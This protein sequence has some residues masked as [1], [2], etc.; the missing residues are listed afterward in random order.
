[1]AQK[2]VTDPL[3]WN[4]FLQRPEVRAAACRKLQYESCAEAAQRSKLD[5]IERKQRRYELMD[6]LMNCSTKVKHVVS[7]MFRYKITQQYLWKVL[8]EARKD[9]ILFG[10]M[11]RR[12]QVYQRL[13]A[14][15]AEITAGPY[16]V[17]GWQAEEE[18]EEDLMDKMVVEADCVPGGVNGEAP[19]RK[20]VLD[21]RDIHGV[22][23]FGQQIKQE[24]NEAFRNENWE[25]ALTRYCQGDELLKNFRAEPHLEKENQDLTTVHRA[26]LNNK[27][28]AA[29]K[30]DHWQNALKASE[31][32][33]RIKQDDEK[34]LFRKAQ[35]LEGLGRTSEALETLDEIEQIAE[36]MEERFKDTI[37]D[38]VEERRAIIKDMEHGA[39][40]KYAH[41]LKVMGKK[42][43]FGG[44]RFLADG[45][46][47]PPVLTAAEEQQLKRMKDKR[48]YLEAKAK[49]LADRR[50]EG[51]IV[52]AEQESSSDATP[53]A[54]PR[55]PTP[56][57]PNALGYRPRAERSV[58]LT[59]AQAQQLLVELLEAYSTQGFQNKVHADARAAAFETPA[60]L[61]RLRKTALVVQQPLLQKWGF[62]PSEEGL[63][64][65]MLCLSDHTLRSEQLRKLADETTKMLYGGE[66]G[67]WDMLGH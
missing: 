48:E 60:F 62:D 14:L 38:D 9:G 31:D 59:L 49:Y 65:M 13:L 64:E 57:E 6:E 29:L 30:M 4:R 32:A 52:T 26:C 18:V 11:L 50:R 15:Q 10:D 17:A 61:R 43:V 1:M 63:Q 12:P 41:M 7:P 53:A 44:G 8:C 23:E 24:G 56:N 5:R 3:F 47:P 40:T 39:A 33:L 20:Q 51:G 28:N 21:E 55:M 22:L 58:T 67:M 66:D 54:E 2:D 25:G 45:S 37:M 27:A 46:S 16:G 36:D 42:E 35:A 34:A 19:D